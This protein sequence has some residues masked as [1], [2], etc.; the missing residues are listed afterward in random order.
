MLQLT[1]IA[2]RVITRTLLQQHEVHLTTLNRTHALPSFVL[3][4]LHSHTPAFLLDCPALFCFV[5]PHFLARAFRRQDVTEPAG[6]HA[7]RSNSAMLHC[8]SS[9]LLDTNSPQVRHQSV[10]VDDHHLCP[11]MAPNPVYDVVD[12]DYVDV[13]AFP[14]CLQLGRFSL[15]S[16]KAVQPHSVVYLK[17]SRVGQLVIACL[18]SVAGHF[19]VLAVKMVIIV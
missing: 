15:L 3:D 11:G 14:A 4:R 1:L 12:P 5:L 19:Q 2:C 10:Q 16:G 9:R 7:A 17:P 13:R 8:P 18:H 6:S